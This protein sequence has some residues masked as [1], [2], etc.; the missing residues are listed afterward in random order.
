MLLEV[1]THVYN[2]PE[3]LKEIDPNLRVFFNTDT[4]Q[5]EVWGRD[6]YGEYELGSFSYL[7]Q[8]V[9]RDIRYGYWLA[10]NTG[11]PWKEFLRQLRRRKDAAD[12]EEVKYWRDLDYALQ[13][14]FRW[15][16]RTLYPGWSR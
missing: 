9:I 8:R 6:L 13:D 11:R 2:I 10:N 4:Q 5:Y 1:K 16:G 7:D 14:D 12:E 15:F 3:R